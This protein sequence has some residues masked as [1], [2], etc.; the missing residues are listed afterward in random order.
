[1]MVPPPWSHMHCP[2]ACGA[3]SPDPGRWG[4]PWGGSHYLQAKDQRGWGTHST[5]QQAMRQSRP[6]NR[7][8]QSSTEAK[9]SSLTSALL[10]TLRPRASRQTLHRP[11]LNLESG[12]SSTYL[13]GQLWAVNWDR[14]YREFGRQVGS[15]LGVAARLALQC[16]GCQ[17]GLAAEM[18][19]TWLA[20]FRILPGCERWGQDFQRGRDI[21]AAYFPRHPTFLPTSWPLFKKELFGEGNG[22]PLQYSCLENPMDRGAWRATLHGV[23]SV[24]YNL[25]TKLPPPPAHWNLKK[26]L[27]SN[28][29]QAQ[30]K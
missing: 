29:D 6:K 4:P 23:T 1:M 17:H 12:D 3:L 15:A 7:A 21:M 28:K 5:A 19:F 9:S 14:Q 24:G 26:S 27:H 13:T 18:E 20:P 25:A 11:M 2:E 16:P 8:Q 30:P 10:H 22:N